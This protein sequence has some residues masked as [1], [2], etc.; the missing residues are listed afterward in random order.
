[1]NDEIWIDQAIVVENQTAC[2]WPCILGWMKNQ[3][4]F[5]ELPLHI[6]NC[7]SI[8]FTSMREDNRTIFIVEPDVELKGDYPAI[9]RAKSP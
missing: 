8:N 4:V 3:N 1:M 7:D 6:L 2:D 9:L 5:N